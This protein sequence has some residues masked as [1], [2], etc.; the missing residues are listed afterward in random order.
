MFLYEFRSQSGKVA[1]LYYDERTGLIKT[2]LLTG[3]DVT[4]ASYIV[5]DY[6]RTET[7]LDISLSHEPRGSSPQVPPGRCGETYR[8]SSTKSVLTDC[9][10]GQSSSS[11]QIP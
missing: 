7:G 8:S 11:V 5:L 4:S 2:N 3:V 9:H 10:Y 1:S 6:I